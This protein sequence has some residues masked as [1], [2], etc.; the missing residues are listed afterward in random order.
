MSLLSLVLGIIVALAAGAGS[1]AAGPQPSGAIQVV[2]TSQRVDFPNEI[3]LRLEAE[4]SA[5]ITQVTLFYRLG[6]Q[7]TRIYG[8][9]SFTPSTR[10]RAD[11]TIKTGGANYIP[12]GIDVEYYYLI[13]DE[14][15]N[16][17]ETERFSL[18]YKDPAFRWQRHTQGE[19][20]VLWHDRS[21]ESV[22]RVTADV[23]QRLEAVK[24]LLGLSE[25]KPM[26]AVILNNGR[27]AERSFPAVSEAARQG[28]VFGGFAFGQYGVF[29]LVGLDRDGMVHELTHLLVDQALDSPRAKMPAWLNEGLAM[30]FESGSQ[31][32]EGTLA[33]AI[34]G[35]RLLPLRSMGSVPGR[36]QDIGLFYAQA[37]S[38][39]KFM[40]DTRGEERMG[41]LLKSINEGKDIEEAVHQTYGVGLDELERQW[42]GWLGGDPPNTSHSGPGTIGTAV[43]V[44]GAV[45]VTVV[46]AVARWLRHVSTP[47]N[48]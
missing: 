18:E 10:V 5:K 25:V 28:H 45:A 24:R 21:Q 42:K 19:I 26:K 6:S 48:E 29:V 1:V 47:L 16:T 31:G 43:I 14:G 37:W 8:Y 12:S 17:F 9:P 41:A 35:R 44:S 33:R 3:A 15:G 13:R 38:I 34:D 23:A 4:S 27:E 46:V 20:T 22:A 7:T 11:F 30:Y 39:V 32:R 40:V 2:S 36:P